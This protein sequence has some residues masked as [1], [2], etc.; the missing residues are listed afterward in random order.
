MENPSFQPVVECRKGI[1]VKNKSLKWQVKRQ[2][3]SY[4]PTCAIS[5]NSLRPRS[6]SNRPALVAELPAIPTPA[7]KSTVE[8]GYSATEGTKGVDGLNRA[9]STSTPSI[10]PLG[11]GTAASPLQNIGYDLTGNF[12][13][14]YELDRSLSPSAP[15]I[16]PL[17]VGTAS[18]PPNYSAIQSA[19][20]EIGSLMSGRRVS[21]PSF[22]PFSEKF[23]PLPS[24][25]KRT[26]S[27]ISSWMRDPLPILV[28]GRLW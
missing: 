7:A 28:I 13:G 24:N 17:S 11:V 26:S 10:S 27:R 22:T 4:A 6:P 9:L 15:S 16:S 18:S 1:I 14:P 5:S 25:P 2:T 8:I 23:G 20:S 12:K 19:S 21:P 3:D